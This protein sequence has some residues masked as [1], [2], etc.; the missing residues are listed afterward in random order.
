MSA[1]PATPLRRDLRLDAL[2]G[3]LVVF[4][5]INHLVDSP[6]LA[7]TDQSLGFIS[8]AEGFVFLSGLV[9]G[10]SYSVRLRD[11]GFADAC[12]ATA[13][14]AGAVYRAHLVAYLGA[15]AWTVLFVLYTVSEPPALPRLFTQEP[16]SAAALGVVLLHQ[17]AR[18][19]ILPMYCVFLLLLPWVLR[20]VARGQTALVLAASFALWAFAQGAPSR[21]VAWDG[22][23]ELGSFNPL[24]WQFLFVAGAVLGGNRAAGIA[25]MRPRPAFL[26][27][28]FAGAAGLWFVRHGWLPAPWVS[29][30][31]A[32]LSA[33]ASLGP[34]RVANF[35]LLA[36]C[37]AAAAQ[38]LPTWFRWPP[39]VVVGQA[40]LACFAAQ[41]FVAVAVGSVPEVFES[42][43][44]GRW[45]ATVLMLTTVFG[46][47]LIRRHRHLR[48]IERAIARL[49]REPAP[50]PPPPKILHAR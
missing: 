24:A 44:L 29:E 17:P 6:L 4:M 36:Y 41:A 12:G 5:A 11:R 38:V 39:F 35:S 34:L 3:L 32:S 2:R 30:Q 49:L 1:T 23:I 16:F 26:G 20:A 40:A 47:A 19:D 45:G 7:V 31:T 46:T 42:S 37:V 28:A 50:K 43:L 18:L 25:T 27:A 9:A 10:W 14:R 33:A 15:L 22:R 13:R 21:W 48:R 8:S